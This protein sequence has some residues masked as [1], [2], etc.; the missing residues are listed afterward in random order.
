MK[1]DVRILLLGEGKGG[2]RGRGGRSGRAGPGRP[3]LRLLVA[4]SPPR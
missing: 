4:Q 1:R 2:E 3:R